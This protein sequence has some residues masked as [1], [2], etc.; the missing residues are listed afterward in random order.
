[1]ALVAGFLFVEPT[2]ADTTANTAI[3]QLKAGSGEAGYGTDAADP[4]IVASRLIRMFIGVLGVI[5]TYLFV[6]AGYHFVSSH[7]NEE[8][9]TKARK[10]MQ[11]AVIGLIII[12]ASFSISYFL[13]KSAQDATGM[14]SRGAPRQYQSS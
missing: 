6:M 2:L 14:D 12:L 9:V 7:G 3:E 10:M 13:G 1:M 4:R 5:I 8:K 11:G